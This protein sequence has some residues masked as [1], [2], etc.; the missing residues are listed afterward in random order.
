MAHPLGLIH[1]SIVNDLGETK[2]VNILDAL[3]KFSPP[4][5][6]PCKGGKSQFSPLQGGV[7]PLI[8]CNINFK[9][10]RKSQ[11]SPLQGGVRGGS[12]YLVCQV[13]ECQTKPKVTLASRWSSC[14]LQLI[15]GKGITLI[16]ISLIKTTLK[17][18]YSLLRSAMGKRFRDDMTFFRLAL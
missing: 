17:P 16:D 5:V 14:E 7:S 15:G 6:P 4:S 8:L 3:Y 10:D 1:I 2:G 12:R 13:Y 11:F 18:S 9:N